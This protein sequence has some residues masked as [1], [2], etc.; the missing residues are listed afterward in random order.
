MDPTIFTDVSA[1]TVSLTSVF[2]MPT[3]AAREGRE[4]ATMN[5]GSAFVKASMENE[6][7][8]LVVLDQLS[9]ALLVKIGPKYK[10]FMDDKHEIVVKLFTVGCNMKSCGLR[11]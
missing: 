5:V 1:P 11:C 7:E 10:E 2:F 3:I 9:A 6:E 4:I 8:V